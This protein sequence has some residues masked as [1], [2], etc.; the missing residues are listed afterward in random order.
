MM[1]QVDVAIVGGG[2]VGMPTAIALA[3][4]G[5]SSAVI[6]TIP[7]P[8]QIKDGFDGRV[9]A[10]ALG[11]KQMLDA[12]GVWHYVQ[13]HAEPILDIRVVDGDAPFFLHYDHTDVGDAPFGWIVENRIL[14]QALFTR[15][16]E[17]REYITLLSPCKVELCERNA[18]NAMLHLNNGDTLTASLVIAADGRQSETRQAAGITAHT[19]SYK[20]TAIVCTIAHSAP[21]HGLALER[22][23]PVGPFAVLP[24]PHNQSSLVWTES[25]ER[26]SALLKLGDEALIKEIESRI[27]GY[28]GNVSAL[29]G[30]RFSYPLTLVHAARYTTNRLALIG[31]AAHGIHPIAGQGVNLGFRDVA[32]IAEILTEAKRLGLDL[33]FETTLD[34]Y[35]RWRQLDAMTMIAVTDGLTRLF[36]NNIFPLN[37]AR[38]LGLAAVEKM[39]PLKRYFMRHAMG[40]VGDLPKLMRGEKL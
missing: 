22:F 10:I 35:A 2:L 24:M 3:Q 29:I 33:G 25:T 34:R 32:A 6:E 20:Q 26:A 15:A 9:C 23:L 28:L 11:S 12:I 40:I 31:D 27:G 5:I 14:R 16:E 4:S 36:S 18:H 1:P 39:P 21:H 8:N 19:V 13:T 30:P 7:P 37:V 38:R 17:L